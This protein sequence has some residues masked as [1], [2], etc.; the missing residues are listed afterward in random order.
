VKANIFLKKV[1]PKK[2]VVLSRSKAGTFG[3]FIFIL[4]LSAFMA[5]PVIYSF[6]QAFKPIG[7]LFAYPPKFFVL[8]PTLQ[9][10]KDVFQLSN[11]LWVP[12]SRYIFN[13]FF[14]SIVG[15]IVYIFISA[16]MAYPLA[17]GKFPGLSVISKLI[18][19]SMLF[20]D[21]LL[22]IPRYI[23]I[24]K[25]HIMDTYWAPLLPLLSM[26]LGV[27]LIQQYIVATIPDETLEAARIDGANEYHI[28]FGI[29]MPSIKPAWLTVIIFIFQLFWNYDTSV[30]IYSD[31]LK[32]IPA[33]IGTIVNGGVA[34]MGTAAAVAVLLIIPPIIIFLLTQDSIRETMAHSGL[35]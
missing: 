32:T 22:L 14:I 7:E 6:I 10:F 35:K 26:S 33:I 29:V 9:N 15:T 20:S 3:I 1:N 19:L 23:I 12:F 13:S 21:S 2:R 17:K 25:L 30:Y 31:N 4:I 34:R 8:H 28:F 11:T 24:S 27:F 18:V 5:L 16:M